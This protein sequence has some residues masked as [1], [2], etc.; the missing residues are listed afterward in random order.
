MLF[1][2]K[3]VGKPGQADEV[4]EFVRADSSIAKSVNRDYVA[5]KEVERPITRLSVSDTAL[6]V[7][8]GGG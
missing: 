3:L 8:D 6:D 5:L 7:D 2:P 4:I 1:V